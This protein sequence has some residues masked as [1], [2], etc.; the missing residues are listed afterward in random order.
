MIWRWHVMNASNV[1]LALLAA[2][3]LAGCTSDHDQ[4][5]ARA[6]K[7]ARYQMATA[8]V[9]VVS[10]VEEAL[11]AGAPLTANGLP[12]SVAACFNM[13]TFGISDAKLRADGYGVPG[14]SSLRSIGRDQGDAD[15]RRIVV[16]DAASSSLQKL[17]SDVT[18]SYGQCWSSTID[19]RA[20]TMTT[21][22]RE[23]CS[24][25]LLWRING[26]GDQLDEFLTVAPEKP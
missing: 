18:V 22:E 19:L 6:D 24:A 10:C 26:R 3:A 25:D 14:G 20:G 8:H 1:A 9:D 17:Y 5:M 12:G 15:S 13:S 2:L 16:I 7:S 4:L 23:E 21:P 11:N